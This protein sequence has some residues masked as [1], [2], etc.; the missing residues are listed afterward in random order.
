MISSLKARWRAFFAVPRGERFQAHH[1]RAHRANASR[2]TRVAV[3][4]ASLVLLAIGLALLVL[5][6]PGLLLL[7]AGGALLAAESLRA[8]RILDALDLAAANAIR[9]WRARRARVR[10][11]PAP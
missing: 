4:A 11:A 1:R 10:S 3:I 2:W 8:A 6:G 7:L 5:P 9:R